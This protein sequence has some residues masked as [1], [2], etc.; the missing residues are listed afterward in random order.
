MSPRL[1][2]ILGDPTWRLA[3]LFTTCKSDMAVSAIRCCCNKIYVGKTSRRVKTRITE[4]RSNMLCR[5]VGAP[6]VWHF[7]GK[8]HGPRF[9][10][11]GGL[12]KSYHH[13][14]NVLLKKEVRWVLRLQTLASHRL[15]TNLGFIIL[16][17]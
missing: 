3:S 10:W 13:N 2:V 12:Y 8:E 4:H 5:I 16:L 9:H 1:I 17:S 15:N 7:M 6:L 14:E 11:G